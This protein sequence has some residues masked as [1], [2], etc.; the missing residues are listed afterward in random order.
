MSICWIYSA[1]TPHRASCAFV[2]HPR[3]MKTRQYWHYHWFQDNMKHTRH[4][5]LQRNSLVP[6]AVISNSHTQLLL[7]AAGNP[8]RKAVC[9]NCDCQDGVVEPIRDEIWWDAKI[10]KDPKLRS[11][12]H[13]CRLQLLYGM[14]GMLWLSISMLVNYRYVYDIYLPCKTCNVMDVHH[15]RRLDINVRAIDSQQIS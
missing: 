9:G 2:S 10:C 1:R 12:S 5:T 7:L 15:P 8:P 4:H 14:F 13:P 3:P 6:F 11:T